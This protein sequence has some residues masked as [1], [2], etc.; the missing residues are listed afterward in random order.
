MTLS[1]SRQTR[2]GFEVDLLYFFLGCLNVQLMKIKLPLAILGAGFSYSL[3]ILR[4]YFSSIDTALQKEYVGLQDER[5]VVI[6]IQSPQLPISSTNIASVMQQLT[7]CV[8]ALQ[9]ENSNL[10]DMFLEQWKEYFEGNSE[11]AVSDHNFIIDALPSGRINDLHETAK[12][13]VGAGFEKEFSEA[14]SNWRRGWLEECLINKLLGL[15]KI[16]IENQQDREAFANVIMIGRWITASKVTLKILFPGERRLCDHVFLGFSSAADRCFTEVCKGATIHLLNFADA[17]AGG[18]PSVSR[19][20]PMVDVFQTLHDLIPQFQSL[21]P[22]SFVNEAIAVHNRLGEASR[23]VFVELDNLIFRIPEAKLIA[24]ADGGYHPMMDNIINHLISAC[25]SRQIL[26]QILQDYPK[27]ANEIGTSSLFTAK[28]MRIMEL[29]ERKLVA[30]SKNYNIPALRYIF[31][32]N[33]RKRIEMVDQIWE[34]GTITGNDWF[35]KN[36]A[37][38]QHN[39]ELYQ[40]SSWNKLLE[41]LKLDSNE[42]VAP[43]VAAESMKDKL[44]LFNLHFEE[45]CRV[46]STWFIYNKQLRE[47]IIT[48]VEKILL[49]AYGNFIGRLH[50]VLGRHAYECIEYGMF[51]IQDRLNHLFLGSNTMIRSRIGV[52]YPPPLSSQGEAR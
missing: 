13:M 31:M 46:Q 19:L 9:L 43:N 21:F 44:N 30:K 10:I 39:L 4:S 35:G 29:L 15:Q 11:L 1:L 24:P 41:F 42:S 8:K 3:I 23:D 6:E 48:S 50:D 49:P 27:D 18:S 20:F 45:I 5:S 33:N 16:N 25:R 28:M 36:R 51:D 2:C 34:L 14:Y 37:K 52:K 12:L 32:M 17:V 47:E 7:I 22:D 40:S 26:E 38:V